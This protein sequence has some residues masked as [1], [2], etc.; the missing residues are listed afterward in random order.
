MV[1]ANEGDLRV[2][3]QDLTE[4]PPGCD[5]LAVVV[6]D[7]QI[8]VLSDQVLKLSEDKKE[9]FLSQIFFSPPVHKVEHLG[10]A[11]GQVAAAPPATG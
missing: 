9:D 5:L 1:V 11:P 7:H 8:H 6:F 4:L 3:Q 10:T 2:V